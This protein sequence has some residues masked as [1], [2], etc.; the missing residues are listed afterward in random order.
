MLKIIRIAFKNLYRQKRRTLLT[1]FII[2]FGVI[3]VLLFS[4]VAGSFKTMMVG[5]ITDSMLGHIQIHRNGYVESLDN[6]PLNLV[7]E[8]EDLDKIKK[9]LEQVPAIES[10]SFRILFGGML[11]DYRETT[12]IK[13]AALD[14]EREKNVIPLLI[15]R[16][17]HGKMLTQGECLGEYSLID[18]EP[19]SA[20]VAAVEPCDVLKISR[21]DFGKIINSIYDK[22]MF[23][24]I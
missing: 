3:A 22:S 19:A 11:S 8:N 18:N 21:E 16:I 12:N 23:Q 17:K 1:I 4:A 9:I 15:S 13:L 7:I 24:E 6:M 14:P 10:Y 5:Q 2:A 20:S